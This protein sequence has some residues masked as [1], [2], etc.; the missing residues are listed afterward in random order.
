MVPNNKPGQRLAV[1]QP[2]SQRIQTYP[3]FAANP[4]TPSLIIAAENDGD[5]TYPI[6]DQLID[7]ATG[8]T[9]QVTIYGGV[10]NLISDSHSAEGSA[11]ITRTQERRRVADWSG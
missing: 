7:R 2:P 10:H 8:P 5:L 4:R 3:I 11:R 6:A 1:A 9:T